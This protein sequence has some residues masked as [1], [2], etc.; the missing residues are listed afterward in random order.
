MIGQLP[1]TL[2]VNGLSYRINTYYRIALL[3]FQAYDDPELNVEEKHMTC[4]NCLY[5]DFDMLQCNDYATALERAIWFLDGGDLPKKSAH[6]KII[7]W[8]QDEK[9]IFPAVNRVAGFEVRSVPY[10]HWWTFLGYFSETGEGLLS[11][12]LSIRNKKAKGKTLDKY[13]QS[14]Y[15]E[16]RELIDI[17]HKLSSE[18]QAEIDFVNSLL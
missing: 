3:I 18:E 16:H 9:I 10:L 17:K 2:E 1:E 15:R 13:E 7:D 6:S 8:E 5:T 4:L 14:I 11:T 12:V